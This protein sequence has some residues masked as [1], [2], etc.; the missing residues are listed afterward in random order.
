[1]IQPEN[2]RR[3]RPNMPHYGIAPDQTDAMLTWDWA[4]SQLT[5]A[6]NY[7]ICATRRDG[8]PHAVPIWGT[9][10]ERN[11]Y[12][13]TDRQSLKAANIRRDNRVVIHLESGDDTVIFE[14]KLVEAQISESTQDAIDAAYRQKYGFDPE[15]G[16]EDALTYQLIPR[17]VMAGLKAITPPPRLTGSLMSEL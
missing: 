9:W 5:E 3:V 10:V 2:A 1:M 6:R 17:K 13:G 4:E 12:F 14:G 7:W 11:L 15:L 8:S 16:E